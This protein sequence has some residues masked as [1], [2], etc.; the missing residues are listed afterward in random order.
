MKKTDMYSVYSKICIQFLCPGMSY[1]FHKV[2][3]MPRTVPFLWI[4]ACRHAV[5]VTSVSYVS[6]CIIFQS[7][8]AVIAYCVTGLILCFLEAR[9]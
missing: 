3:T 8:M 5:P 4:A 9:Q 2:K 1:T 6:C 7:S